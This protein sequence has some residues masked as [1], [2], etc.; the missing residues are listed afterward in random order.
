M[1]N[2]HSSAYRVPF[3]FPYPSRIFGTKELIPFK[4]ILALDLGLLDQG[5]SDPQL[6]KHQSIIDYLHVLSKNNYVETAPIINYSDA[7]DN[8]VFGKD[9]TE[10]HLI[11]HPWHVHFR[12]IDWN[13]VLVANNLNENIQFPELEIANIT[14]DTQFLFDFL[15][16]YCSTHN[17]ILIDYIKISR[18]I[19]SLNEENGNHSFF[20]EDLVDI[21]AY[22]AYG[23]SLIFNTSIT[24]GINMDAT[25]I[26]NV[27]FNKIFAQLVCTI[28][29]N[30]IWEIDNNEERS[31]RLKTLHNRLCENQPEIYKLFKATQF[32]IFEKSPGLLP[33]FLY[34]ARKA[35]NE[36]V[37][38]DN[39]MIQFSQDIQ[40]EEFKAGIEREILIEIDVNCKRDG[41]FD[42]SDSKSYYLDSRAFIGYED[43]ICIP[44]RTGAGRDPFPD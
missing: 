9:S 17:S 18:I 7:I 33:Y 28:T 22:Y 43:C 20:E 29:I 10:G 14:A 25:T 32:E 12:N 44:R 3:N 27:R 23:R 5:M 38:D 8:V 41:I 24:L 4:P 6:P 40:N 39:A 19:E 31:T 2:I 26:T 11:R 37:L 13:D 34:F 36:G 30:R 42:N 16:L 1:C 35:E 15:G 21:I